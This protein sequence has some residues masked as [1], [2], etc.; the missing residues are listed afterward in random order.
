MRSLFTLLAG[1]LFSILSYSQNNTGKISGTI[2]DELQKQLP[3]VSV[4]LL[5]AKD[6]SLVKIAITDKEGKY[7]FEKIK[8]GKYLLS[9]SSVGF[10]KRF[11]QSFE[12]NSDNS[13]VQVEAIKLSA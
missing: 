6:S 4:S 3:A 10:Q 5:R 7:E 11:G 8:E 2:T 1:L 13:T 12:I 9:I